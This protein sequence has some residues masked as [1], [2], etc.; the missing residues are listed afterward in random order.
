M[1]STYIVSVSCLMNRHMG[2]LNN[3][4]DI[5]MRTFPPHNSQ[6]PQSNETAALAS[7]MKLKPI[8]CVHWLQ[9]TSGKHDC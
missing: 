3:A 5:K 4:N 7:H 8:S 1:H 9:T 2:G 6:V